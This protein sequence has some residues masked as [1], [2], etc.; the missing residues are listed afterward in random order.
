M[1]VPLED[2]VRSRP[3][4]LT[5]HYPREFPLERPPRVPGVG[6]EIGVNGPTGPRARR[7]KSMEAIAARLIGGA[8]E[9]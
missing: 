8:R 3:V 5:L 6:G 1:D 4:I 9:E 2:V 7:R